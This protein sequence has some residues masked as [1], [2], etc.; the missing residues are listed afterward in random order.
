MSYDARERALRMLKEQ[1][2]RD[3][4]EGA[5]HGGKSGSGL[6]YV[7][8]GDGSSPELTRE[9]IRLLLESDQIE[10]KWPE[11]DGCFVLKRK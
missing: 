9:D 2:K 6:F 11:Y 4:Y 5:A 1:P 8:Y 3:I 10:R 7:T